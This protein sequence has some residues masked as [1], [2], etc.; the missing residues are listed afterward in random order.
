MRMG[1]R[2]GCVEGQESWMP[3]SLAVLADA[4]NTGGG[5]TECQ[6]LVRTFVHR[7]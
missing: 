4:I 1:G 6:R 3:A 7:W 5:W 2:A